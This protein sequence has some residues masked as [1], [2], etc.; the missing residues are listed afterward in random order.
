MERELVE[1]SYLAPVTG[2]GLCEFLL[3]HRTSEK[4]RPEVV[5]I[6]FLYSVALLSLANKWLSVTPVSATSRAA[7]CCLM[8][9]GKEH[10]ARYLS[11][12]P[13][14]PLFIVL[15]WLIGKSIYKNK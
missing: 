4:T 7:P 11:P 13:L 1:V 9:S 12:V 3:L 15:S 2:S 14:S 8:Q 10:G 5:L 6:P